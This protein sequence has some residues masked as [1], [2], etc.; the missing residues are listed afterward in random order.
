MEKNHYEILDQYDPFLLM[1]QRHFELEQIYISPP[2]PIP[3]LI[4]CTCYLCIDT[5]VKGLTLSSSHF[6]VSHT[7]GTKCGVIREIAT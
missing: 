1:D 6:S 4:I 3:F 7:C 2:P 5:H